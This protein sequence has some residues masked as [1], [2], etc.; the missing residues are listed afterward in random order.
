M[1]LA[2]AVINLTWLV[3]VKSLVTT[4]PTSLKD[5]TTLRKVSSIEEDHCGFMCFLVTLRFSHFEGWEDISFASDQ[6]CKW[7]KSV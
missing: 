4:I 7:F 6:R 5:Q 2:L 3:H 1:R